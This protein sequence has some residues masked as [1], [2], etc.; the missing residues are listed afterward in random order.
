VVAV[1]LIELALTGGAALAQ[2]VPERVSFTARLVDDGVPAT[3]SHDFAFELWDAA[4]EG[5]SV[6]TET[7]SGRQ[8]AEG[9]VHIELGGTTALDETVFDG[10]TLFLGITVDGTALSPRLPILSVP[11]A[12]RAGSAAI[13]DNSDNAATADFATEAGNAS[14]A[15][16][17][18]TAG[19]A[20]NADALG[21]LAA[22]GW[23]VRVTG[24]CADGQFMISV[25]P[26]GSVTCGPP[27]A[28]NVGDI[29]GVTAGAG[30][31]GGGSAGE[32]TL[33]VDPTAVQAR[34]TGVCAPGS[35]IQSIGDDGSVACETDDDSG[36][37]ITSVNA[38]AGGGLAGGATS[39]DA[40]L[41]LMTCPAGNVLKRDDS[42]NWSCAADDDALA[43]LP[44]LDG[45]VPIYSAITGWGCG[46]HD[47]RYQG[48][49]VTTVVVS[50]V[51][52]PLEN[53]TALKAAI[54][55]ITDASAARP[56]LLKLEPGNYDVGDG[57]GADFAFFSKPY[58]DVAG[59]GALSTTIQGG[60]SL[61]VA[62]MYSNSEIR[63]ITIFH[64]GRATGEVGGLWLFSD[65]QLGA[66]GP[67]VVRR[68]R[69]IVQSGA[70]KTRALGIMTGERLVEDCDIRAD[71]SGTLTW[72]VEAFGADVSI[73]RSRIVGLYTGSM[74]NTHSGIVATDTP[75]LSIEDTSISI[76]TAAG[77]A[78]GILVFQSGGPATVTLSRI[79]SSAASQNGVAVGARTSGNTD[80]GILNVEGGSFTASSAT[81]NAW[82]VSASNADLMVRGSLLRA[83]S[84][85]PSAPADGYRLV[86][87][88]GSFSGR[89]DSSRVETVNGDA[90]A[91]LQGGTGSASARA[92]TSQLGGGIRVSGAL[93]CVYVYD[94]ND[95]PFICP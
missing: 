94:E 4:T 44:C 9:L 72:A 83:E 92:A 54:A 18:T 31:T 17:A 28:G 53:G 2:P 70:T 24:A 50:P 87:S 21:G 48:R 51:G 74:F 84:G 77:Q 12:I 13:A 45:E 78:N 63:D 88:T 38:V 7:H 57:T 20:D 93:K 23:Q 75:Q 59:S 81:S 86:A 91:V 10:R 3:G 62:H 8:V 32:V 6:W 61:S 26:D 67:I 69:V 40:N 47:D 5:N 39:G 64:R 15:D 33:A 73:R 89:L 16:Y 14:T 49:F 36:G 60:G 68:V 58:V 1:W 65:G 82:A 95:D 25:G 52:T 34:V 90:V 35:S 56:Y 55:G 37:D 41:G 29:T 85:D 11:Y 30:L 80:A 22:S 71:G 43:A 42:G 19:N 76:T 27:P 66:A 46:T 79:S